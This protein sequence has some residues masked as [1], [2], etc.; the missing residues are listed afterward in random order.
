M[1]R[2]LWEGDISNQDDVMDLWLQAAYQG[3]PV[4]VLDGVEH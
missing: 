4:R 3:I 1:R 2:G